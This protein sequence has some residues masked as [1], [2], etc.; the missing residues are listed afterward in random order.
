[1]FCDLEDPFGVVVAKVIL[2]LVAAL[3]DRADTPPLPVTNIEHFVDQSLRSKVSFAGNNA[4]VL[5][6]D[7]GAAG[8]KLPDCFEDAIQKI[9]RFKSGD[10]DWDRITGADWLVFLVTHHGANMTRSEKC[11][12]P[13]LRRLQYRRHHRRDQYV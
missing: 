6:F 11:L 13:I 1:D 2:K 4:A 7:F 10:H 3:G 8:F 12:D 9:R 5:V